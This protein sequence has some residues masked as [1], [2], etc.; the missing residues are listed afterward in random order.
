MNARWMIGMTVVWLVLGMTGCTDGIDDWNSSAKVTGYVYTD[1]SHTT[2]V[3]GVRVILE[4]DPNA[5]NPY[6]GPDR[7]TSTNAAG[8][9]EGAVFLGRDIG[10]STYIYVGDMSVGYFYSNK[11][12][13]WTGGIT[14]GPGSDFT[15][16]PVD[17]TMFTVIGGQ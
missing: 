16:P 3:Q 11:A 12:F 17:T 14:V 4:S 10:D 13:R 7:W 15:L 5:A 8:Y 9:F 1:P 2:G 6:T